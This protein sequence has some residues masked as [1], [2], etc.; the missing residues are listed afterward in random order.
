MG[1]GRIGGEHALPRALRM[2][3]WPSPR[4]RSS[5]GT[6]RNGSVSADLSMAGRDVNLL[7]SHLLTAIRRRP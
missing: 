2:S 4:H 5:G 7:I 3:T 6:S 1:A